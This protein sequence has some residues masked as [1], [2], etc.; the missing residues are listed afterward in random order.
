MRPRSACQ[1]GR[2]LPRSDGAA[3]M[4]S[5][6]VRVPKRSKCDD[7]VTELGDADGSRRASAGEAVTSA[8]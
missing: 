8:Q 6:E 4:V 5:R 7:R 3:V 1:H 2:R